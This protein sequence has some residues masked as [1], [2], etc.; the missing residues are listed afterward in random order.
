MDNK[1]IVLVNDDGPESP[2]LLALAGVL[3]NAGHDVFIATTSAQKSGSS[4]SVSF[5]VRYSLGE[6]NGYKAL[7]VDG[8]PA[9]A[10][11]IALTVLRVPA[12]I[13][14]SG[15]NLGPNLGLWDILSSG[16]VGAVF[17]GA[18]FGKPGV[19]VSLVAENSSKYEKLGFS[20]YENAAG[21]LL[22][23]LDFLEWSFPCD[24]LNINIPLE[25]SG[26]VKVTIPE[27]TPP[28]NLYMCK[29]NACRMGHWSLD[30]S[31]PCVDSISDIC[32]VKNGAISITPL[33]IDSFGKRG[34]DIVEKL[35]NLFLNKR[36]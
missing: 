5:E 3:R 23:I 10:V 6:L 29:D 15:I 34:M 14:I 32:A 21:V 1:R 22:R 33:F 20:D 7:I 4:K 12:D 9:S 27:R 8:T 31:Y 11:T 36:F 18:L 28:R 35:Q 25:R 24:A 26:E 13:I 2:G 30:Y 17:E 16:T 19:A